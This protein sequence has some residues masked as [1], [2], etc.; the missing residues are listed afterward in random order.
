V[1]RI[2]TTYSAVSENPLKK[3]KKEQQISE[4]E[5]IKKPPVRVIHKNQNLKQSMALDV[6]RMP[7]LTLDM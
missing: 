5:H 1:S 7:S 3:R 6:K 2:Y 4:L